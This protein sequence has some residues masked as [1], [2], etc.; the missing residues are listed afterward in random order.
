VKDHVVDRVREGDNTSRPI[1][2][3]R[4]LWKQACVRL[5]DIDLDILHSAL[6]PSASIPLSPPMGSTLSPPVSAAVSVSGV[7]SPRPTATATASASPLERGQDGTWDQRFFSQVE[8][9]DRGKVSI[10]DVM[11][12]IL[13]VAVRCLLSRDSVDSVD[14]A[15]EGEFVWFIVSY[16]TLC[17]TVRVVLCRIVY[18][19]VSFTFEHGRIV[20]NLIASL[21]IVCV[22]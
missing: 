15:M 19:S 21:S 17:H 6:P 13:R 11:L 2:S 3:V 20:L 7:D 16:H 8:L 10:Q 14:V 22:T 4:S 1:L 12:N 18:Y 5:L 9:T